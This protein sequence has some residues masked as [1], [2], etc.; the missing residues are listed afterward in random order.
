MLTS[1]IQVLLAIPF[2]AR[3]PWGYFR[4]AFEFSRVFLYK[5]TVNWRFLSEETFLSREFSIFLLAVHALLLAHFIT[6]RWT[7]PSGLNIPTLVKRVFRPL[8]PATE[9]QI[10]ARIGPE[11]VM[12]SILSSMAIGLLCARTLHYQFYAYAEWATPFLLWKSGFHPLGIYT[13]WAAQEWA[14]NIFPSTDVS[15]AVVVSCLVIQVFG[16][17]RGSSNDFINTAQTIRQGEDTRE[18]K[19]K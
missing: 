4:R 11:F 17:W 15:S 6:T 7:R 9:R 18:K 14:W 10:A 3:N 2:L 5:W 1:T 19:T 8:P 16:V 13:V 12:T